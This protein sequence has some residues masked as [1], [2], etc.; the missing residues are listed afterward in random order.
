MNFLGTSWKFKE[1]YY[2]WGNTFSI[3]W[4]EIYQRD[5]QLKTTKNTFQHSWLQLKHK[6]RICDTA[7]TAHFFLICILD[8]LLI[9]VI[10]FIKA[11]F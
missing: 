10:Q 2:I 9:R 3:K 1:A 11:Y 5:G 6:S 8:N 4:M 7:Y